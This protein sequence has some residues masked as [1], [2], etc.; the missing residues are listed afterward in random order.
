[1]SLLDRKNLVG[2]SYS[3]KGMETAPNHQHLGSKS[4]ADKKRTCGG[5]GIERSKMRPRQ[6]RKGWH[7]PSVMLQSSLRP[8]L[9]IIARR[10]KCPG[11]RTV[12]LWVE[13]R[14][15]ATSP[16]GV[17]T[18]RQKRLLS[19]LSRKRGNRNH[20]QSYRSQYRNLQTVVEECLI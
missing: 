8:S 19:F 9:N 17:R 16:V 6:R 15:T 10:G 7:H 11:F 1:M 13:R 5:A 18:N 3:P 4:V 2:K 14:T 12:F 20:Y